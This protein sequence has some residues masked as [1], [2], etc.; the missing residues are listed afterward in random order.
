MNG[1]LTKKKVLV[2]GSS[3][4]IGKA[5]ALAAAKA[6]ADVAVHYNKQEDLA[7]QTASEIREL[8]SEALVVQANLEDLEE[9]DAMFEAIGEK[10][11]A[12]D[13]FMANA[14]AT[15]FK[16][17]LEMKPYHIDRT[18][19]LLIN[20]LIRSAQRAVPLMKAGSGRIITV[21]GHGT[22]FTLP[23]YA[24]IGSA[25]GAVETLTRYLAYELGP[26][27]ITC[28]AIAP[29]VVATDS[30]KFY[31]GDEQY[32]AF[33]ETVSK[34]TPLGRLATPE[35]IADVA[36]F[37]ASDMSRFVTGEVIKV[38]GGLTHTSGPF[39]VMKQ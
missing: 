27:G 24:S 12:L 34:Q 30:A 9:V 2:T 20:S 5:T 33:D 4:G 18:Y 22:D 1:L 31:M 39:E 28:N 14:A 11:G 25:K 32:A 6:G 23:N 29:G 37:L 7:Q 3:R 36:V 15:A 35:D 17:L 16:P 26:K 21:T 10:W 8:G 19:Q 38:D 13:V